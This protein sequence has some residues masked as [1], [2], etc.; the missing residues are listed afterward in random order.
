MKDLTVEVGLFGDPGD[1]EGLCDELVRKVLKNENIKNEISDD[2]L[3]SKSEDS[4]QFTN[5]DGRQVK[6]HFN[7]FNGRTKYIG[8][9]VSKK[10]TPLSL[11]GM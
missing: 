7:H 9:H 11:S 6:V 2:T 3:S 8:T 5:C 10:W 4:Y 1:T